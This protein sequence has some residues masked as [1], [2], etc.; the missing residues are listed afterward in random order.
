MNVVEFLVLFFKLDIC[1]WLE[2]ENLCFSVFE[3]VFIFEIKVR[4]VGNKLEIIE[5]LC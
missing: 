2:G 3:G 1:F 5:F 4:V